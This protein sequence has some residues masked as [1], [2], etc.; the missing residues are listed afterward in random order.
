M[1]QVVFRGIHEP[2]E[3]TAPERLQRARPELSPDS[4]EYRAA[5]VLLVGLAT[6]FNIDRIVARTKYSREFVARCVRRLIDNS[7]RVDGE[8]VV[9][10]SPENLADDDFWMDVEVALGRCHRKIG[11]D[12][13]PEWAPI[14]SWVK[15]FDFTVGE[16]KIGT[17]VN[18]YVPFSP[19]NPDPVSEDVDSGGR[20]S[21]VASPS[22]DSGAGDLADTG[23]PAADL[24]DTDADDSAPIH[25]EDIFGLDESSALPG[26]YPTSAWRPTPAAASDTYP[27]ESDTP[28]PDP[29]KRPRRST[30]P[31]VDAWT[32]A[33]WLR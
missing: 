33:D 1:Y 15:R 4:D 27:C 23:A 30:E 7:I 13:R 20:A 32:H 10:W 17:P 11:A 31:L 21:E 14:G 6:S 18:E 5:M 29:G 22:A 28:S 16:P 19:Y 9:T 2:K 26:S 25:A 12:G 3:R 8:S 24:S